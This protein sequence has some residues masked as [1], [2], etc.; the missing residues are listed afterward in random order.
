ML[1]ISILSAHEADSVLNKDLK[2]VDAIISIWDDPDVVPTRLNEFKAAGGLVLS[3]NMD[4]IEHEPASEVDYQ[5]P[6]REWHVQA[7]VNFARELRAKNPNAKLLVHCAAGISR[8]AGIALVIMS[9][10]LG[11]GNEVFLQEELIRIRPRCA[12]NTLIASWGDVVLKRTG[13]L[14]RVAAN[15]DATWGFRSAPK[16]WVTCG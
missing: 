3:L 14:S 9:D 16:G 5:I 15:L 7:A 8:S 4:D 12:P 13:E 11:P 1:Q 6:P 2:A 10:E